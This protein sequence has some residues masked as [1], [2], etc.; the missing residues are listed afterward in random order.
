[1]NSGQGSRKCPGVVDAPFPMLDF[2]TNSD[3]LREH[4]VVTNCSEL[5]VP[6]TAMQVALNSLAKSTSTVHNV[7]SKNL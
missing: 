4:D 2:Y 3:I 7:R 5:I 6:G 1:M